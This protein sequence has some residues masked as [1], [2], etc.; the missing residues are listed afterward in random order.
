MKRLLL[1]VLIIIALAVAFIVARGN[2]VVLD[3]RSEE[4]QIAALVDTFDLE[5]C[6]DLSVVGAAFR[7]EGR[8]FTHTTAFIAGEGCL[9]KIVG[10]AAGRGF[11]AQEDGQLVSAVDDGY[12]E[13]LRLA[14]EGGFE[15]ER[16]QQ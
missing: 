6:D 7:D 2:Q 4:G 9:Q 5:R 1:I 8:K 12:V 11:T 14:G 3:H 15:W 10:A 16:E 13:R